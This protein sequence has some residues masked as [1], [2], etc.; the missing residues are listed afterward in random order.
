MDL[1]EPWTADAVARL[2][3]A[4]PPSGGDQVAVRGSNCVRQAAGAMPR[5]PE[6]TSA[7]A[8][9]QRWF[10]AGDQVAQVR[11]VATSLT[12]WRVRAPNAQC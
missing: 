2:A 10:G 7:V 1:P 5:T 12:G 8:G 11:S 9:V 4:S 3:S 6:A